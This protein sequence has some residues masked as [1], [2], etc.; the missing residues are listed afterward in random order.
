MLAVYL[1]RLIEAGYTRIVIDAADRPVMV[2][3]YTAQGPLHYSG[4]DVEDA[5]WRAQMAV[6]TPKPIIVGEE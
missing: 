6:L 5:I 3:L 1:M 2:T 4:K